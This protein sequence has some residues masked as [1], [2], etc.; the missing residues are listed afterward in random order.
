MNAI[1]SL[2]SMAYMPPVKRPDAAT[3]AKNIMS[4]LDTDGNGSLGTAEFQTAIDQMSATSGNASASTADV[5]AAIDANKDGTISTSE[6]SDQLQTLADSIGFAQGM[7]GPGMLGMPPPA[8][9]SS[10]NDTGFTKDELTSQLAALNDSGTLNANDT[11]RASL[12]TNVLS[13]FGTADANSDGR[14]TAQEAMALDQS[15]QNAAAGSVSAPA[16]APQGMGGPGGAPPPPPSASG[17][18]ASQ[19]IAAADTNQDGT[20]SLEELL[21]YN[22]SQTASA[23]TGTDSTSSS[24]TAVMST[25]A[26]LMRTYGA[27]DQFQSSQTAQ[28]SQMS[29]MLSMS[30]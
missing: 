24:A 4:A 21:A 9:G 7:G 30:A 26:K 1:S 15:S 19:V 11:A 22:Q 13:Q 28:T 2:S 29:G 27:T 3:A 6:L 23:T 10:A 12:L 8:S 16:F 20:V 18:N 17:T 5:F 25:V 14:V